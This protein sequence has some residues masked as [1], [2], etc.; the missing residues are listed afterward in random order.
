MLARELLEK[1]KAW[2]PMPIPVAVAVAP[3]P[4]REILGIIA[5]KELM[6]FSDRDAEGNPVPAGNVL[7][8]YLLAI[9]EDHAR[10]PVGRILHSEFLSISR[11]RVSEADD[12]IGEIAA[13]QRG[14]SAHGEKLI[15]MLEQ[16]GFRRLETL[17]SFWFRPKGPPAG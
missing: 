2:E 7:F 10:G 3:A 6:L 9:S 5:A 12:Y 14:E 15:H 17:D 1:A 13:P 4:S 8:Y 16:L 11:R